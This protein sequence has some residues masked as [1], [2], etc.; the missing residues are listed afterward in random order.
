MSQT[1]QIET[2]HDTSKAIFNIWAE[3][4][5]LAATPDRKILLLQLQAAVGV[6]HEMELADAKL[7]LLEQP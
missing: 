4:R 7:Q 2:N 5:K 1:T 6:A 3:Q